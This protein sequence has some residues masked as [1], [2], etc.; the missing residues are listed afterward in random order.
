M[1]LRFCPIPTNSAAPLLLLA[2]D[3]AIIRAANGAARDVAGTPPRLLGSGREALRHLFSAGGPPSRIVCQPSAAG[4]SWPALLATARDP[5]APTGVVVVQ[6]ENGSFSGVTGVPPERA[7]LAR[8]LREG[9]GAPAKSV[10]ADSLDLAIGLARGEITVRYQPVLRIRDQR[11]VLLE[12]LARWHRCAE[13]PIGP[14]QFVPLAERSGQAKAL[15]M[16]VADAAF[17]DLARASARLGA[18][19]SLNMPLAV[20][21]EHDVPNWLRRLMARTRFPASALV[22]ELTETS[23]VRDRTALRQ[24]LLRLN[25]AGVRVLVDDLGLEEDR[26]FLLELPFAGIKLD[27][28]L[29]GA[30]PTS[31]RARAEVQRL[32][33]RAHARRMTVTAEGISDARLWRAVAAAGVDNAQGF[34]VSRPLPAAALP[35]WAATWRCAPTRR[36][37]PA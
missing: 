18:A 36:L 7:A 28:H 17:S 21:L 23:P 4:E 31:R 2:R 34:A 9:G 3:P 24:A 35:A 20:L 25:R 16:A 12:G 29:I 27:R 1:S 15:T 6:E 30:M 33:E 32:V 8:A 22:L 5:F 14:D 10:G 19:L 26:S 37:Y 11:P 13:T